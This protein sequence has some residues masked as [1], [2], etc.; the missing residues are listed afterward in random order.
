M[1][2]TFIR[3]N[4]TRDKHMFASSA[5]IHITTPSSVVYRIHYSLHYSELHYSLGAND[6]FF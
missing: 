2:K 5:Y 3:A 6:K 1:K 4:N